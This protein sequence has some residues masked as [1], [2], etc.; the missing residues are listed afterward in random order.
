MERSLGII[1][2]EYRRKHWDKIEAKI[3]Q[4]LV[5]GTGEHSASDI[6]DG[7]EEGEFLLWGG[8]TGDKLHSIAIINLLYFPRKKIL[9]IMVSACDNVE[10]FLGEFM[11]QLQEFAKENECEAIRVHGRKGWMKV[12]E[13]YGF[14]QPYTILEK[15]V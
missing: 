13:K 3:D 11:H 7:L 6:Y 10:V 4:A 12:L 5:H 1:P 2:D 15:W 9:N 8:L 14:E